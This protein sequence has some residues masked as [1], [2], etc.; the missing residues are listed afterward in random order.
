VEPV[1]HKFFGRRTPAEVVQLQTFLATLPR[2][3][4]LNAP[5]LTEL[6]T[7]V[8]A[9]VPPRVHRL[10]LPQCVQPRAKER[11]NRLVG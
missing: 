9:W 1:L 10:A 8:G 5:A 2:F 11:S 3:Q 6:A 4:Q 7:N